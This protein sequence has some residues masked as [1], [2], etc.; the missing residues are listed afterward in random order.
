M[1]NIQS[2]KKA[3]RSSERKRVQNQV[4]KAKIKAAKKDLNTLLSDNKVNIAILNEKITLFQKV[5]DKAAKN[6]VIHKNKANRLKSRYAK[7]ATAKSITEKPA[8]TTAKEK[9]AAAKPK[10]ATK[11]AAKSKKATSTK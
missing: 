4:W 6:H 1:P 9:V 11:S 7:Q 2:A 8:V 3:L 5:L 10:P